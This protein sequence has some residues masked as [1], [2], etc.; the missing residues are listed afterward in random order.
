MANGWTMLD[1]VTLASA[2]NEL[3]TGVFTAYEHLKFIISAK[4][5]SKCNITFGFGSSGTMD[6]SSSTY[7]QFDSDNAGAWTSQTTKALIDPING[8]VDHT[9]V[10][11]TVSN[12]AGKEKLLQGHMQQSDTG[13]TSAISRKEVNAKIMHSAEQI[14]RIKVND[15]V[16]TFK[17]GSTITVWGAEPLPS[18]VFNPYFANGTI[19]EESDTGKHYM[20]DGTDTWNEV[21]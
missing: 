7:K 6:E 13:H 9:F 3:D 19:F 11:A 14:T 20:F 8:Y 16:S 15:S 5:N 1:T 10:T 18:T 2:G 17:I 12:F 4:E 21:S